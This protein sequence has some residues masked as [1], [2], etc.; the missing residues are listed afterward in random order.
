MYQKLPRELRDM[1]FTYLLDKAT[2]E[3]LSDMILCH[4]EGD[5]WK[6]LPQC[7]QPAHLDSLPF[8]LQP[9][10]VGGDAVAEAVTPVYFRTFK[11]YTLPIQACKNIPNIL[12]ADAFGVGLTPTLYIR[13]LRLYW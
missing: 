7:V 12:N 11:E 5:S 9:E 6:E 2:E 3:R 8:Y 13:V 4:S 1:V 10:C